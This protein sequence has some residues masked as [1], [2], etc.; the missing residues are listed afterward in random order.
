MTADL[1]PKFQNRFH[2]I[3]IR[4]FNNIFSLAQWKMYVVPLQS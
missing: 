3:T 4:Q 2:T 1:D